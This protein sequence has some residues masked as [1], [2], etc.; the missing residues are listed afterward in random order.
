MTPKENLNQLGQKQI[1]TAISKMFFRIKKNDKYDYQRP[2]QIQQWEGEDPRSPILSPSHTELAPLSA[3]QKHSWPLWNISTFM[4]S[5]VI[6][7]RSPHFFHPFQGNHQF[8]SEQ[9]GCPETELGHSVRMS[10]GFCPQKPRNW[11]WPNSVG[12]GE[13]SIFLCI[14]ITNN[15]KTCKKFN[16]ST[17][18]TNFIVFTRGHWWRSGALC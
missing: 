6:F 14:S 12:K 15:V 5:C 8:R 9:L 10:L 18:T 3:A 7:D 1:K 16:E 4:L 13:M 2:R 11:K 17:L